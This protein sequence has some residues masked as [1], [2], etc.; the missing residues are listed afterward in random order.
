MHDDYTD[1]VSLT[2]L[3]A[4]TATTSKTVDAI[5]EMR[6]KL[7]ETAGITGLEITGLWMDEY[8]AIFEPD[9]YAERIAAT[10]SEL[11]AVPGFGTF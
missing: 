2:S 8:E 1:A 7:E 10:Q 11:E 6:A 4:Y 3:D 9:Q 5:R